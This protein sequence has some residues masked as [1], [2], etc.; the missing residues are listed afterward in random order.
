MCGGHVDSIVTDTG[1]VIK[2]YIE[3]FLVF[4]FPSAPFSLI[5]VVTLTEPRCEKTGLRGFRQS[6]TQSCLYKLEISDVG[7][8][9]VVLAG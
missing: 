3:V 4:T 5:N 9:A 2:H 7:R 8:R 1:L 6:P